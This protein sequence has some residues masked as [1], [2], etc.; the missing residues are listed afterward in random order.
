MLCLRA[1]N[2]ERD[3]LSRRGLSEE[4]IDRVEEVYRGYVG[5]NRELN[6][7]MDVIRAEIGQMVATGSPDLVA[8]EV[9]LQEGADKLVEL[10]LTQIRTE[11][12]VR[13]IAG[14]ELWASI[15]GRRHRGSDR[16]GFGRGRG[17][18]DKEEHERSDDDRWLFYRN[19]FGG[20]EEHDEVRG[21]DDMLKETHPS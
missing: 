16:R 1:G 11:L 10:R 13:E 21:R 15:V 8:V 2:P 5:M 3:Y 19:S 20:C 4:Q 12:A 18:G 14:D 6:A 7:E 9:K 17:R